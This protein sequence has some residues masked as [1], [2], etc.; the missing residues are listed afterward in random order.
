MNNESEKGMSTP[1]LAAVLQ[2]RVMNAKW[3]F[4]ERPETSAFCET[5]KHDGRRIPAAVRECLVFE[6]HTEERPHVRIWN[7]CAGC[8]GEMV[9]SRMQD[10]TRVLKEL[11]GE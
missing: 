9:I 5:E 10:I 2:S 8:H 11:N 4:Q 6:D 1:D 7:A 3:A